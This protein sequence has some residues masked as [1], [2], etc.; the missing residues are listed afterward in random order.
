MGFMYEKERFSSSKCDG[1]VISEAF[2]FNIVSHYPIFFPRTRLAQELN[3]TKMVS[4]ENFLLYLQFTKTNYTVV[5]YGCFRFQ[6]LIDT[7]FSRNFL[8]SFRLLAIFSTI[9]SWTLPSLLRMLLTSSSCRS[10]K[11]SHRSSVEISDRWLRS[12]STPLPTKRW[13][14]LVRFLWFFNSFF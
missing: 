2:W 13:T 6:F 1:S 5:T 3:L 4:A 10:T 7:F 9:D 14:S 8:Y 11:A 12:C